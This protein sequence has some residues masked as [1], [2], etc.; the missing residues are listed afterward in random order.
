MV[1]IYPNIY[2]LMNQPLDFL[3]LNYVT[4]YKAMPLLLIIIF[5]GYPDYGMLY[6]LV[7]TYSTLP[8]L[9]NALPISRL[10]RLWNALPNGRAF[11]SLGNLL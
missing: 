6:Q 5:V 1:S 4:N 8:R 7:E 11:H 3:T 10:P 2:N 9:W